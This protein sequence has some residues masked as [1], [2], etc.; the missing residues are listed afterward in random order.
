M[1]AATPATPTHGPSAR[2]RAAEPSPSRVVA[3][4]GGTAVIATTLLGIARWLA[5]SIG[6]LAGLIGSVAAAAAST[7]LIF[8]I[9]E[10]VVHRWIM[11]RP[12]RRRWLQLAFE[13]HHRAHHWI[14][15]PPDQYIQ[16]GPVQ[17][18]PLWTDRLDRAATTR[19]AWA[20]TIASHFAFY[21]IFAMVLVLI[22]A[23]LWSRNV[24]FAWSATAT[25]VVLLSGFIHVHDA[26]HYPGLSPLERFGWFRFLDRHHYIHHID[27]G[28]NTNFL[29]P[30]GD[31]LLGTL[32][33]HLTA[34][35]LGRWPSYEQAR[36]QLVTPVFTRDG[37][38]LRKGAGAQASVA[39]PRGPGE[40]PAAGGAGTDAALSSSAPTG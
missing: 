35:E 34:A 31:L 24:A 14:N 10:W 28:A 5:T 25:S 22:P 32:R 8:S 37:T 1:D 21:G 11:H 27:T 6:T 16:T 17:Y 40:H 30:L 23:W 7:V 9:A 20:V 33:R 38:R 18:V 29:L 12:S 36:R 19:V 39:C 2:G 15:F 4:F 3:V 26:I 13:Q